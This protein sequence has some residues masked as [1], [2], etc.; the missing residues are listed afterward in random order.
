MFKL[1]ASSSFGQRTDAL[2]KLCSMLVLEYALLFSFFLFFFVRIWSVYIQCVNIN[3]SIYNIYN[4][5][6]AE[7]SSEHS[8]QVPHMRVISLNYS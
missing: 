7:L 3:I 6:E 4:F 5:Y 2:T 1:L 8:M